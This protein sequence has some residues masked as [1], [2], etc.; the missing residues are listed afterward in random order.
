M[1]WR[2]PPRPAVLAAF[3]AAQLAAGSA[4]GTSPG[5]AQPSDLGAA[6]LAGS[7]LLHG[8]I[9]V[10]T[11]VRGEHVGQRVT[12]RWTF[13]PQCPAGLCPQVALA[14]GRRTGLDLLLLRRASP[15]RYAGAGMF[16]APLRCAGTIYQ[17][18][19]AVPFRITVRITGAANVEGAIVATRIR[20][21]YVSRSRVNLTPCVRPPA[22]DTAVYSGQAIPG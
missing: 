9:T 18:G 7:Y 6:R 5:S 12:R 14:R 2:R 1:T 17:H 8:R 16:Y 13:L 19:E 22:R 10:A 4:I 15:T 11:D 3:V 21:R 20:A